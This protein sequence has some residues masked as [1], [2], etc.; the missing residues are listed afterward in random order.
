[1]R[2][3]NPTSETKPAAATLDAFV[4]TKLA[5][6]DRSQLRRRI[7]ETEGLDAVRVEQDGQALLNFC[8]N[9]YLGL[10]RH[11]EMIAA[12]QTAGS[13]RAQDASTSE[14]R[15]HPSP[16]PRPHSD[17]SLCRT[18]HPVP[19]CLLRLSEAARIKRPLAHLS[20]QHRPHLT[21]RPVC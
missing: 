12:A 10:T 2:S 1:M 13:P 11:P 3:P 16:E 9:D 17:P 19:G 5:G 18:L 6:L 14:P 4:S 7:V 8:S 20:N 15:P 21:T